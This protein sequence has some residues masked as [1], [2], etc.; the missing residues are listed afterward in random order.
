MIKKNQ[1]SSKISSRYYLASKLALTEIQTELIT[2]NDIIIQKYP[3]YKLAKIWYTKFFRVDNSKKC[4]Y[5]KI[6]EI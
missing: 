5:Q 1:C 2:R 3:I 6:S 4:N